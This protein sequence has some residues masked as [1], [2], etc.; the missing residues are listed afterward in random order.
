MPSIEV[1]S[2]DGGMASFQSQDLLDGII[3]RTLTGA[4]EITSKTVGAYAFASSLVEEVSIPNLIN[5]E[6]YYPIGNYAFLNCSSLIKASSNCTKVG[7]GTF[8]S[9]VSLSDCNFP[10]L[11]YIDYFS[12][13]GC[14]KLTEFDC[15]YLISMGAYSFQN[16]GIKA[17]MIRSESVPT[18]ASSDSFTNTPIASG[19][20]YIYVPKSL[21][22]SYK[23]ATNWSV[24]ASQF[25]VLEDYTVDGT[26]T[27]ELDKSKI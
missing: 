11:K 4:F 3:G 23:T 5:L 19:T 7:Y 27:G 10:N 1:P 22:D 24:Y 21:V 20:G 16:T 14:S 2:S 8:Q 15:R 9:C 6:G 26:I 12:F 13:F 25:R 17:L 18:L